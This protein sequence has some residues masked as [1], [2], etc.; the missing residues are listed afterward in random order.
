MKASAHFPGFGFPLQLVL[1]RFAQV[2]AWL[3]AAARSR[4]SVESARRFPVLAP[5]PTAI[6]KKR[7]SVN[8]MTISLMRSIANYCMPDVA[9]DGSEGRKES[10]SHARPDDGV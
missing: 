3:C 2:V 9:K 6:A 1:Q 10:V 5:R 4:S 7:M 8:F